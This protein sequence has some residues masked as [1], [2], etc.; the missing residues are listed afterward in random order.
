MGASTTFSALI[1]LASVVSAVPFQRISRQNTTSRAQAVYFM[2]NRDQNNIHSLKVNKNGT[3]SAGTITPTQGQGASGIAAGATPPLYYSGPD[4][5]YST[6]ALALSG[7]T[8]LNV[9]PASN[10][11][12]M[13][14]I[15]PSDPLNPKF[16]GVYDTQGHFPNAVAISAKLQQACVTNIGPKSGV[17]CFHITP[18][19]L[20]AAGNLF[21][22][23]LNQTYPPS[24]FTNGPL[25]GYERAILTNPAF[26]PDDSK[27]IVTQSGVPHP[28]AHYLPGHLLV[29]PIN[30]GV[31]SSEPVVSNPT[32]TRTLF[33]TVPIP[34]KPTQ[35]F[36]T[37]PSYGTTILEID[38]QTNEA[39]TL[40][41]T[42]ITG[43]AALCWSWLLP[44]TNRI[45]STDGLSNRLVE[46]DVD[47]GNVTSIVNG[48]NRNIGMIDAFGHG[49][50]LYAL[51][52]DVRP[53]T[54]NVVTWDVSTPGRAKV[55]QNFYPEGFSDAQRRGGF[56][57]AKGLVVYPTQGGS[58][59]Y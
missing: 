6:G 51:S 48:T 8:L 15:D 44:G 35:Y 57:A 54:T 46:Q 31:I 43:Q 17:S 12:S 24:G 36:A 9:N 56:A 41:R 11:V 27:L 10:T 5:L 33:N 49:N 55:L 19:G 32:G 37:D 30:N 3:L 4:S 20:T 18:T 40:S 1:A 38:D 22:Y 25:T 2:D 34:G 50:L 7:T 52:V 21:E 42:N 14:Q 58:S 47:S 53:D 45:F 59:S 29:F 26:S 28:R 16:V 13:F 23:Q 39:T